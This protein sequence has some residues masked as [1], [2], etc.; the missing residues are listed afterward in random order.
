MER[1]REIMKKITLLVKGMHCASCKVLI[2]DALQELGVKSEINFQKGTA[3]IE[4]DEKKISLAAIKAA[5]EKEGDYKIIEA[6][7]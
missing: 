1:G 7:P 4:F 2:E 6:K 3:T 5:I